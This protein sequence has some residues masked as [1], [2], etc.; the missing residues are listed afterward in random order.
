MN[1]DF[2]ISDDFILPLFNDIFVV[3]ERD[4]SIEYHPLGAGEQKLLMLVSSASE[5]F[6]PTTELQLLETI[7][8]K[9]L[10]K[11]M[12]DV[13]VVNI[14]KFPNASISNIWAF[15]Q[16][17]QVII[18][19]C[20]NWI[21]TQGIPADMHKQGYVEGSEILIAGDLG[22]YLADNQAKAKLWLA[23]QKMF[24]N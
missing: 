12:K 7:V 23:L 4:F 22:S 8:D 10:K 20:S 18:W 13:W 5:E 3:K 1:N 15:F 9:G 19:G 21:Q 2:Q 6:L 16:P 24:F 17:Q 11:Q 14:N